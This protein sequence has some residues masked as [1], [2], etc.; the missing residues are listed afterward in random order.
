[1]APDLG[2]IAGAGSASGHLLLALNVWPLG[3]AGYLPAGDLADSGFSG[4]FSGTPTG[5]VLFN[6]QYTYVGV[7]EGD[8]F[9]LDFSSKVATSRHSAV[10]ATVNWSL[11]RFGDSVIATNFQDPI[12]VQTTRASAFAN[13]ITAGAGTPVDAQDETNYDNAP[14]TEG[15][16][17]GGTGHAA[18]DVITLGDGTTVTVD[19]VAAGVVTQFTVDSSGSDGGTAVSV[20]VGGT[21]SQTSTTG[22]GTGFSLTLDTD[23][24]APSLQ[25][26]YVETFNERVILGNLK[27][28]TTTA[29]GPAGNYPYHLWW[30]GRQAANNFDVVDTTLRSGFL[31]MPTRW[32]EITGVVQIRDSCLVFF[33]RAVGMLYSVDGVLPYTFG[34]EIVLQGTG[35][36]YPR[37]IKAQGNSAY[38][39]GPAGPAVVSPSGYGELG[40]DKLTS[41][42]LSGRWPIAVEIDLD[43]TGDD[44]D[45]IGCLSPSTG[46]MLWR[47]PPADSSYTD[48]LLTW[49]YRT[50]RFT[51]ILARKDTGIDNTIRF[52]EDRTDVAAEAW[53][54]GSTIVMGSNDGDL[55]APTNAQTHTDY[56]NSPATEGT[57]TG[58]TGYVINELITLS[59]GTIVRVDNETGG[60]VDMFTVNSSASTGGVSVTDVLTQTSTTGSGTGFSLTLDVDNITTTPGDTTV[61]NFSTTNQGGESG[62]SAFI[63]AARFQLA[64][65]EYISDSLTTLTE[66]LLIASPASGSSGTP[67]ISV[68]IGSKKSSLDQPVEVTVTTTTSPLDDSGWMPL[69]SDTTTPETGRYHQLDITITPSGT[70]RAAEIQGAKA[71]ITQGGDY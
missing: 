2:H 7:S 34:S 33:E 25:A 10:T 18:S 45:I 60:V 11:V 1:M 23:N 42:L 52:L 8:I 12:L 35:T 37:S 47:Y 67:T 30:S 43:R 13:L 55:T 70:W 51:V 69:M 14:T 40:A 59:E 62:S 56:D 46:S 3:L 57:F 63:G 17:A 15:T 41:T 24:F 53:E 65:E 26:K 44:T 66:L 6:Q 39:W 21:L 22:A 32:G 9:E 64:F 29:I 49:N 61:K 38:F 20:K 68:T 50:G 48:A 5:S 28:T 27:T 54:M 71:R 16:F 31:P 4:T 36:I 58:G 19:A